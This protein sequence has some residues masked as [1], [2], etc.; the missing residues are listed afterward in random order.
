MAKKQLK[1]KK[2][3]FNF[4]I[5]GM[6]LIP[7]ISVSAFIPLALNVNYSTNSKINFFTTYDNALDHAIALGIAPDY[8]T[9]SAAGRI[10]YA[11]YLNPFLENN[12]ITQYEN[13]SILDGQEVNRIPIEKMKVNTIVLNEWMKADEHK[14]NGIVNNVIY[15]SMGDS[16]A[17]NYT[18]PM[19]LGGWNYKEQVDVNKAFLMQA[20]GMDEVYTQSDDFQQ[21]AKEI[22]RLENQ[23]VKSL[24]T[25]YL[26]DFSKYSIGIIRGANEATTIDTKFYFVAPSVY[27]FFYSNDPNK[28]IGLQFPHPKDQEFLNQTN[29]KPHR[30]EAATSNQLLNQF[31]G[32]FDHLIYLGPDVPTYSEKPVMESRIKMMLKDPQDPER[33]ITF[34]KTGKWYTSAWGIIGKRELLTYLIELFN[35]KYLLGI[36]D[37]QSLWSPPTKLSTIRIKNEL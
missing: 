18:D 4:K 28:G 22:S 25:R 10:Q 32:K 3:K 37:Y 29:Y 6:V 15:T 11:E 35:E 12:N 23:R 36:T 21:K 8:D 33:N 31:E 7:L 13:V 19:L 14:F 17:A 27:P 34:V 24:N 16:S 26:K 20:K 2:S 5:F 1:D 9:T 30:I